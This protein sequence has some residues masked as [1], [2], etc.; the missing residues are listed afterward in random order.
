[1]S[2]CG[3]ETFRGKPE[4]YLGSSKI[5]NDDHIKILGTIYTN[6]H[7]CHNRIKSRIRKCRQLFYSL[8]KCGMAYPGVTP[9]FKSYIWL[10]VSVLVF[11]YGM[12]SVS[13]SKSTIKK[14]YKCG[15]TANGSNYH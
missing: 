10:S 7:N 3:E 9:N 4:R 13:I 1:M 2:D 5:T 14:L 6:N 15:L 11:V 8:N 12:N